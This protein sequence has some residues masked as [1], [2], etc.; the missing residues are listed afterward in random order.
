MKPHTVTERELN[1]WLCRPQW[2]V[3]ASSVGHDSHKRL[4]V[5][6]GG[7]ANVFRVTDHDETIFLGT[8]KA[9]AITAYNGSR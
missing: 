8:D 9:A 1:G 7:D 6:S 4:E 2:Q 5:D 3:F